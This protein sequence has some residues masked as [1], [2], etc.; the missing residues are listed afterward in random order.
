MI[1]KPNAANRAAKT[2]QSDAA[3]SRATA[4]YLA[5]LRRGPHAAAPLPEV[6]KERIRSA[7]CAAPSGAWPSFL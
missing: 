2:T 4:T 6:A 7:A 5:K 3:E 1:G